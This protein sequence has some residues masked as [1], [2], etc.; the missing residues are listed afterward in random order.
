MQASSLLDF[1]MKAAIR[2]GNFMA[3]RGAISNRLLKFRCAE[4]I[5][6]ATKRFPPAE[7]PEISGIWY[8]AFLRQEVPF[9]PGY[10]VALRGVGWD[11]SGTGGADRAIVLY[12]L[13]A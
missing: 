3:K 1:E 8:Q 10:R 11:F 5:R 4:K 7:G 12:L 6:E 2:V 13:R 9:Q